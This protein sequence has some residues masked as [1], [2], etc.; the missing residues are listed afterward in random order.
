MTT[1]VPP[2]IP[3]SA[4]FSALSASLASIETLIG[5]VVGKLNS[6][7]GVVKAATTAAVTLL[8]EQTI[9]AVVL[10]S[11]D[12]VLV[13]NQV[14]TTLNGIYVVDASNWY[15]RMDMNV[16]SNASGA[17]M[18]VAQGTANGGSTYQCTKLP[19]AGVVGTNTLTFAEYRVTA[20]PE[21]SDG[22]VQYNNNGTLAGD[23]SFITDGS[24]NVGMNTLILE[25]SGLSFLSNGIVSLPS[26]R[27][28]TLTLVAGT[29]TNSTTV[30]LS[31]Q[32]YVMI[33]R[34]TAGG[35]LGHLSVVINNIGTTGV[36]SFT[37]NS[38]S[39]TDTST[40]N[41]FVVGLV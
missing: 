6:W 14:D 40:V 41:W 21:G 29:A 15:R 30:V 13:K 36:A 22:A 12:Y 23:N 9:D 25:G 18:Y 33:S 17:I 16:G 35:T 1:S 26:T 37:I 5:P 11:G 8:G 39:N 34:G 19:G 28:G 7:K 38:T 24:G 4:N 10:V 32:Q 27:I 20:Y 2:R 31:A 3:G